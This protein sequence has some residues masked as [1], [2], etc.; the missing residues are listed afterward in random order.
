MVARRG[1]DAVPSRRIDQ[2]KSNIERAD[3]NRHSVLVAY[4]NGGFPRFRRSQVSWR[5]ECEIRDTVLPRRRESRVV[6]TALRTLDSRL[7][8]RTGC[9]RFPVR[10]GRHGPQ[11][12]VG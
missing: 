10:F 4:A 8:G 3:A 6:R 5:I 12:W 11:L 2:S 9:F 1:C 7:R